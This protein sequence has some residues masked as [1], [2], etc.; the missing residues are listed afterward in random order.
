[1][2]IVNGK[3]RRRARL[4]F[5]VFV[6]LIAVGGIIA[7]LYWIDFEKYRSDP[8]RVKRLSAAEIPNQLTTLVKNADWPQWRGPNRDGMSFETG[9]QLE[10]PA[11]GPPLS[12]KK[13]IGR[14]FSSFA[15]SAGRLY[16]M[17]QEAVADP[18][19]NG[20]RFNECVVCID[21]D[22]GDELWRFR[23]PNRYDE[24]FGPGP[25]STPTVSGPFVYA[26]GPTGIF[27]C[28]NAITG[29]KIWRHDLIEE[30]AGRAMQYGVS[31]S[32]LV[33]GNLVYCTPGG[34]GGNSVAAFDKSTGALV[35]KALD[36]PASY[37]SPIAITAAGVRQILFLTNTELVSF[38][39][40]GSKLFWRYPWKA[41]GGFNI[42]T[43]MS[44]G[45]YVLIASGYGKGCA[46]LEVTR[47]SDGNFQ[48]G[49]VYEHNRLRPYFASAVRFGE[50]IY[51]FDQTDLVCMNVRTGSITWREK[52]IRSFKKGSIIGVEGHLLLF[53]ES[54]SLTLIEA[55][56]T[57]YR[58]R[59]TCR[60][61]Q[62]RCWT[63]P[64]LADGRLYIRDDA[65][66]MCFDL[67]KK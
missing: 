22:T 46:L 49:A 4:Y 43:P 52:G 34:S 30:F 36:D 23:Y 31:F 42:A 13:P 17:D 19:D 57:E 66:I 1:M 33:D 59:A 28:L 18:A 12:W 14:G 60:V 47:S 21:A 38:A 39:P 24:R 10:W 9:L 5:G 65:Q 15:V 11:D 20:N 41:E 55:A 67:R 27:H 44:F 53:G 54:G 6:C 48:V 26:V 64:A 62:T 51:G 29:E 37:S 8:E 58:E 16:T 45:D 40:D 2:E 50:H 25:R 56:P 3:P 32:P 7:A 63:P 61:S 35:W